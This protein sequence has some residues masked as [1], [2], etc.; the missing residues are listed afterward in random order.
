MFGK[1]IV[2]PLEENVVI[3][4]SHWQHHL[5]R[6][7]HSRAKQCCNGSKQDASILHALAKTYFFCV[8]HPIQR[9]CLALAAEKHFLLFGGDKKDAFVHS[10]APEVPMYMMIDNQYSEWY[11]HCFKKKLDKSRVLPVLHI[12]Q[13]HPESDKLWKRHINNILISPTFNLNIQYMIVLSIKLRWKE[14][15][16]WY[17][18][19]LTICCFNVNT[20]RL[21]KK[22]IPW[23]AL[24]YN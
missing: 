22:S 19:W 20:K 17:Y 21:L 1:D 13:G 10:P 2:C 9:Q 4:W 12:L 15:K 11:F 24:P 6:D 14:I 7:G 16:S 3:L 18:G 5:K 8:E 23:L